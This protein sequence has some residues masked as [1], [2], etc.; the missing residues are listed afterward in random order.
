MRQYLDNLVE[1]DVD[2]H[3]SFS[4]HHNA[5]RCS[6]WS[7]QR[8]KLGAMRWQIKPWIR[9]EW[10]LQNSLQGLI[11][12][13]R[14]KL[15]ILRKTFLHIFERIICIYRFKPVFYFRSRNIPSLFLG[16][17]E[18]LVLVAQKRKQKLWCISHKHLRNVQSGQV[19]GEGSQTSVWGA[20]SSIFCCEGHVVEGCIG[21]DELKD[22]NLVHHVI[23][24]LLITS[25]ANCDR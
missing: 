21:V 10:L 12:A 7:K 19:N 9:I 16:A 13:S 18:I 24:V 23:L 8:T 11:P 20:I 4:T 1:K 2:A 5:L 22:K 3:S 15:H 25:H 14:T 6:C 17:S